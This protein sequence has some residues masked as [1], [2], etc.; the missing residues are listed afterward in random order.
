MQNLMMKFLVMNYPVYRIRDKSINGTK[1]RNQFKRTI[2]LENG[3]NYLLSDKGH[4]KILYT[5]LFENLDIIFN[6]EKTVIETV[7]KNFLHLK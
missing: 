2:V 7:L 5:K 4:I 3:Q 6:E 1:G